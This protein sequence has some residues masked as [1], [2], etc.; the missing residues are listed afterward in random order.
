[1]STLWGIV[2]EGEAWQA[3]VLGSQRGKYDLATEQQATTT[4]PVVIKL[5]LELSRESS[6]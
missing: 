6:T 4:Q 2:E 3:A 5:G 1:M